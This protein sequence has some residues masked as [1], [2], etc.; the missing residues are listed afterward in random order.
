MNMLLNLLSC[1]CVILSSMLSSSVNIAVQ[2]HNQHAA[3]V[4]ALGVVISISYLQTFLFT[5]KLNNTNYFAIKLHFYFNNEWQKFWSSLRWQFYW[6]NIRAHV[7]LKRNNG[8]LL[9][10]LPTIG[11]YILQFL[12][13]LYPNNANRCS[14]CELLT[15]KKLI[16]TML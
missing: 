2:S 14:F 10:M 13:F 6:T 7:S 15:Y 16:A 9:V 5:F 12:D 8:S 4:N 11:H 1:G 3:N